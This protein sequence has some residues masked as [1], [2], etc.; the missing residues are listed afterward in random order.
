MRYALV[1][2]KSNSSLSAK[3]GD[4][5]NESG[6]SPVTNRVNLK[7][8]SS[9]GTRIKPLG[10]PKTET[11]CS[12]RQEKTKQLTPRD[13]KY[14]KEG[15]PPLNLDSVQPSLSLHQQRSQP[16]SRSNRTDQD[17][18]HDLNKCHGGF[19]RLNTLEDSEGEDAETHKNTVINSSPTRANHSSYSHGLTIRNQHIGGVIEE[20]KRPS[21]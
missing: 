5:S 21:L 20:E 3:N 12:H 8:R 1:D 11:Q 10:S 14:K 2:S 15:T 17:S 6:P 9:A 16:N 4:R 19:E 18:L 13:Y 7:I